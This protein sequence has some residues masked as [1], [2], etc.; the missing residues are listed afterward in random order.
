M[1][2]GERNG[3]FVAVVFVCTFLGNTRGKIWQKCSHCIA[4]N[5][6]ANPMGLWDVGYFLVVLEL[7]VFEYPIIY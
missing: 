1:W 7:L 3:E 6:N 5:H 2:S 4:S